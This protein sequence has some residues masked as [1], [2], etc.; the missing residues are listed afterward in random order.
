MK[1][2]SVFLSIIFLA[3]ISGVVIP[4][5]GQE[6]P[7]NFIILA[8]PQFGLY[9]FDMGFSR[10]TANYEFAVAAINRLRP[11]F[12]IVLGDLVNKPS[13]E[14]QI[15]EF[16]RISRKIDPSIPIY[17]VAGNHD[18][19][20]EPSPETLE[21]YRQKIGPDFYSF[22]SGPV[23]GIVL[24]SA[25]FYEP[26][27]AEAE[28]EKQNLWLEE[29]LEKAKTSGYPQII[30]FQHH[31]LFLDNADEPFQFWN[32]PPDRRKP[33]LELLHE[34]GIKYVFAGHIHRNSTAK[35]KE[36]EM[37]GTGPV[38]MPLGPDDSGIRLVSVIA[39]DVQH[40]YF[41]FGRMPDQLELK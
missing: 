16:L 19:G 40:R 14:G 9:E 8:D 22:R 32:I 26:R 29:E 41:T 30:I 10:E 36:L 23:Y 6:L 2:K 13:D 33:L 31:P 34:Y 18:V 4:G 37:T 3:V 39:A 20:H 38:G 25:L 35:D 24:N 28:F 7:C 17:Y 27:M 12:V 5:T 21:S 15:S 1:F 11:A